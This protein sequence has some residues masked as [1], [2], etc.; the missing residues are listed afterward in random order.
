MIEP[1]STSAAVT[2]YV[3]VQVFVPAGGMLAESEQVIVVVVL[4]SLTKNGDVS[5]TL[6]VFA[7]V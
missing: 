1:A 7:K 3:P 4:L 6:P 2:V 5:V